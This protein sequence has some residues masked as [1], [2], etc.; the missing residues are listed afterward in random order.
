MHVEAK[1]EVLRAIDIFEK[2]G[3]MGDLERCRQL[4]RWVERNI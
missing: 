3:A 1:S 2:L 4:L